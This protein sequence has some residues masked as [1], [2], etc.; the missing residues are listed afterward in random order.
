MALLNV[1]EIAVL[2]A[3]AVVLF[4]G[5]VETTVGAPTVV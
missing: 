3:T 2:T 5:I 1:A 4:T